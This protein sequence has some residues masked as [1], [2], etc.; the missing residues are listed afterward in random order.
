MGGRC[1]E[2]EEKRNGRAHGMQGEE[3]LNG[4]G[5]MQG[6]VGGRVKLPGIDKDEQRAKTASIINISRSLHAML[7]G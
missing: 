6:Y 1:E 2:R 7:T 5:S 4:A 3:L